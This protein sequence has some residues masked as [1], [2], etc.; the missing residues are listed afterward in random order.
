MLSKH[1][2]FQM[3]ALSEAVATGTACEGPGPRMNSF[4]F[5]YVTSPRRGVRTIAAAM[6]FSFH[7]VGQ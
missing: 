4:V 6:N 1:V 2:H 7:D 5:V 3:G